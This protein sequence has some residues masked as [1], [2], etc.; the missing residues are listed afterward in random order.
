MWGCTGRQHD[1]A[2]GSG[3][4]CPGWGANTRPPE[5]PFNRTFQRTSV[6][7]PEPAVGTGN[8]ALNGQP[9]PPGEDGGRPDTWLWCT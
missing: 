6:S 7:L 2:V 1:P 9:G 5:A 4:R 3:L 8:L